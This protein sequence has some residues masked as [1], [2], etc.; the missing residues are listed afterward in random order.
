MT[1]R[2]GDIIQEARRAR[3][4]MLR[5]L[6]GQVVNRDGQ[7]I[8]PQYLFD[9]EEPHR[10]PAPHMLREL[11]RV[12]DLEYDWLLAAAG[13]APTVFEEYLEA[14]PQQ[15]EAVIKLFRTA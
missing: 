5:G 11:A 4:L 10:R 8:S 2:V 13:G 12:L 6:T 14:L 3:H 7:P 15:S 1:E 9:I